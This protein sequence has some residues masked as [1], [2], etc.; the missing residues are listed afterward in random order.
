M[1]R[2]MLRCFALRCARIPRDDVAAQAARDASLPRPRTAKRPDASAV[3]VSTKIYIKARSASLNC[4]VG[5][6]ICI[7]VPR[8]SADYL[9]ALH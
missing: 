6:M 1:M 5:S 4:P 3:P 7:G 2:F 9:A 8:V